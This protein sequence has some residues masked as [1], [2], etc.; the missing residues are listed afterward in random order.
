MLGI[1]PPAHLDV[2]I[3]LPSSELGYTQ[4]MRL[5]SP[6]ISGATEHYFDWLGAG[7]LDLTRQ[8]TAMFQGDRI[9]K[10]LFFGFGSYS[11]F[12]RIDFTRPPEA[13]TIRFL[14]PHPARVTLRPVGGQIEMLFE[15]SEDGVVFTAKPATELLAHWGSSL[16]LSVPRHL[17]AIE[18]GHEFAFF[19]QSA[20]RGTATRALS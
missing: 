4:P 3:C 12:L 5:L 7:E 17:L 10:K 8:A 9:G 15:A 1:E 11:F 2:P 19:V 6:D 13:I 18:P 20:R 16:I 14:L